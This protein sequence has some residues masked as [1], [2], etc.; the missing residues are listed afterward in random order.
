[1]P[2]SDSESDYPGRHGPAVTVTSAAAPDC[3][4]ESESLSVA[5]RLKLAVTVAGGGCPGGLPVTVA[6]AS[7]SGRAA[8]LR[9]PGS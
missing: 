1:M 8:A 3:L 6:A 5:R 9:L 4:G 2:E 7:L